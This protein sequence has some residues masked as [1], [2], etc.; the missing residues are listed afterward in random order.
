MKKAA[1]DVTNRRTVWEPLSDMFL[2]TDVSLFRDSRIN[3]LA[4]S[5]Y[6]ISEL[7]SI[8]IEEVYP[9]CVGNLL[10]IA[11]EW[12]GFDERWL[13]EKILRHC[14]S[15]GMFRI[16]N[17]GRMTVPYSSEWRATKMGVVALRKKAGNENNDEISGRCCPCRIH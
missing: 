2:D 12:E 11:G 14:Q 6:S 5:P 9:V 8:L 13:E 3:K 10:C 1:D 15:R 4:A 17:F 16:F 7:E